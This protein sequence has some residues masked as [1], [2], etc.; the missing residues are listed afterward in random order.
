M[1]IIYLIIH[2]MENHNDVIFCSIGSGDPKE[3]QGGIPRN[4]GKKFQGT[5]GTGEQIFISWNL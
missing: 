5:R 3:R 2:R 4:K 1:F